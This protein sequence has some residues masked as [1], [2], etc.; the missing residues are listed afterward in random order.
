[1]T[2]V[3][4]LQMFLTSSQQ[5]PEETAKA[6]EAIGQRFFQEAA[7]IRAGVNH[8]SSPG[9]MGDRVRMQVVGPDGKV[10]QTVDTGGQL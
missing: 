1:M 7:K 9:G 5:G 3:E 8:V 4:L 10:K 2:A 6:L